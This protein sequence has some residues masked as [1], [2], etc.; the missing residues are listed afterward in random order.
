MALFGVCSMSA[1]SET[2]K[3]LQWEANAGVNFAKLTD[4][5]SKV[6]FNI[7][8]RGKIQLPMIAENVY[9]NAGVLLTFKGASFDMGELG[10]TKINA[11][12]LEIPIHIGY[13]YAVNENLS[14]FGEFGP[15]FAFGLFGK[16][17]NKSVEYA[18]GDGSTSEMTE[19]SNNTF[20]EM[21]RF[22]FGLGF[23][24]G[25]EIR[26]KYILS[27]GYDFG[28]VNV[29]NKD[30]YMDPEDTNIYIT[31]TWKHSNMYISLGYKF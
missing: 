18:Y 11:N 9:A 27:V 22:D 15:Y 2:F 6:G 26:Q 3:N 25:A 28:L 30:D 19:T 17:K 10:E 29:Y 24:V 16:T 5:D 12:F 31:P 7:G 23:R 14:V 4:W 20:D 8:V 21:K 1:Q 13:Q